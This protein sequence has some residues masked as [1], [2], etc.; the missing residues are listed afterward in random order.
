MSQS[1]NSYRVVG[2]HLDVDPNRPCRQCGS[3]AR[4]I[5]EHNYDNF[6]CCNDCIPSNTPDVIAEIFVEALALRVSD[7]E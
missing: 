6:D 1:G 5:V 2:W 7:A 4:V 3:P